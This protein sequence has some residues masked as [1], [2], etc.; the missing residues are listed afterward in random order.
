MNFDELK[1]KMWN[2]IFI[3]LLALV[4][5]IGTVRT[6]A[7]PKDINEY[8]NRTAEKV[9]EFKSGLYASGEYQ[10]SV[11]NAL[12]DQVPLAESFK[13]AYNTALSGFKNKMLAAAGVGAGS[14]SGLEFK[15]GTEEFRATVVKLTDEINMVGDHLYYSKGRTMWDTSRLDAG[16][17]KINKAVLAHPELNFYAYYVE[18][19]IENDFETGEKV[20]LAEYL[21][22]HLNFGTGERQSLAML[23]NHASHFA[24]FE[25]SDFETFDKYFFKTDHH[26]NYLGSYKGYLEVCQLLDLPVTSPA[27]AVTSPAAG[28]GEPL[29]PHG[30]AEVGWM[31]GSRAAGIGES[32]YTEVLTVY[33]FD[34]PQ[35][36]ITINGSAPVGVEGNTNG[37]YGSQKELIASAVNWNPDD[38]SAENNVTYAKFYGNDYAEVVLKNNGASGGNG[39]NLLIFGDSYDNAMLKLLAASYDTVYSIDVRWYE[40]LAGHPFDFD[41]YVAAHRVDDVL[42]IGSNTL[43]ENPF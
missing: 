20:Q 30:T 24:K 27:P 40:N 37:D 7:F 5:V 17:E 13:K 28:F 1:P 21:D 16:I 22:E 23:A 11:E 33:R 4:L 8:E 25:V 29:A 38:R 41:Q 14:E 15:S 34:F 35:M 43:F 31:S 42:F 6:F 32:S 18:R 2:L 39:R 26:W 19:E 9:L 36:A 12:A 3:G 10:D